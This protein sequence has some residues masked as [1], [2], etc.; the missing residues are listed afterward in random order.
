MFAN[1]ATREIASL[2]RLT[3]TGLVPKLI[4][5][6][7]FE[8]RDWVLYD[9][10]A[11]KSWDRDAGHVAQLLGR[12]HDQPVPESLPQGPDG[13]VDWKARGREI[14]DLCPAVSARP[15]IEAMPDVYVE[16]LGRA[17]FVHGDPV[18]GNLIEHDGTLTLIDW[19]C[20]VAGDPAEDL[21]IFMSPAM[22]L[23]YRGAPLTSAEEHEFL[24]SYPDPAVVARCEQLRPWVHWCMAAYC[25]WRTGQGQE[26][27]GRA[28]ELE[29]SALAAQ[30]SMES[31][32]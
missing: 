8:G 13:S 32:A 2:S 18:P 10:V 27:Y 29:L 23:L 15:L 21:A 30:S 20:P 4:E 19:Q 1:S 24:S 16:P 17:F 3:G 7:Q 22:Q 25:L 9:H 12:L 14:L 28:M 26:E 6:G 5:P 31:M 11:G